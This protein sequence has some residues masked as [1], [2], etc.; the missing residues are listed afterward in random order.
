MKNFIHTL[1]TDFK[2]LYPCI[3]Y[4]ESCSE[5]EIVIVTETKLSRL[6]PIKKSVKGMVDVGDD[7]WG[8]RTFRDENDQYFCEVDG[9]LYFKGNDQEGEPHYPVKEVVEYDFPSIDSELSEFKE[10][11]EKAKNY[12][13]QR[14][15][16]ELLEVTPRVE[17]NS[18]DV[19]KS[20]IICSYRIK[21]STNN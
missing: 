1:V 8:R 11:I 16:L 13:S 14:E 17:T 21:F 9:A 15:D 3:A 12:I 10:C 5:N 6:Y 20:E 2:F 18:S 7:F 19:R 4:D